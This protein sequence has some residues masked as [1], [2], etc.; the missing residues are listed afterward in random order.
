MQHISESLS[1]DT[2]EYSIC[3]PIPLSFINL[4]E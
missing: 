3:S 1:H 4:L 2:E